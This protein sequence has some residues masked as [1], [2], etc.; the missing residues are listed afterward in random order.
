MKLQR[1]GAGRWH[2]RD[3]DLLLPY[4]IKGGNRKYV[5]QHQG[6]QLPAVRTLRGC[7]PVIAAHIKTAKWLRAQ[8]F[9]ISEKIDECRDDGIVEM[10]ERNLRQITN[11]AKDEPSGITHVLYAELFREACD[12]LPECQRKFIAPK[13]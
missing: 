10:S 1:S 9:V 11:V 8:S 5:I 4:E 7:L 2:G 13:E 3:N 6:K 12:M